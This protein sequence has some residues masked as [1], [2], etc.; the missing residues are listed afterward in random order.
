MESYRRVTA[1]CVF[2]DLWINH[3]TKRGRVWGCGV[4]IWWLACFGHWTHQ[5]DDALPVWRS[6]LW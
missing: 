2:V 4:N 1:D 3:S 6:V 5:P